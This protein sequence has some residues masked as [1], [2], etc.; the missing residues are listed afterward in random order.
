ML[1]NFFIYNKQKFQTGDLITCHY[2]NRGKFNGMIYVFSSE[3]IK[4]YWSNRD[5]ITVIYVYNNTY[6]SNYS[7]K[8]TIST[9]VFITD[10]TYKFGFTTALLPSFLWTDNVLTIEK[11]IKDELKNLIE[12]FTSQNIFAIQE[13]KI[14]S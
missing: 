8:P 7:I 4:R 3:E 9:N 6:N 12:I 5:W 11:H 10:I 1:N 13:G 14:T 2:R